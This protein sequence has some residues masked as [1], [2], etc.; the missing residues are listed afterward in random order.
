MEQIGTRHWDELTHEYMHKYKSLSDSM[1]GEHFKCNHFGSQFWKFYCHLGGFQQKGQ[2]PNSLAFSWNWHSGGSGS[3]APHPSMCEGGDTWRIPEL[4]GWWS[5]TAAALAHTARC[6]CNTHRIN[7]H[8]KL[9]HAPGICSFILRLLSCVLQLYI[10]LRLIRPMTSLFITTNVWQRLSL[11]QTSL[12]GWPLIKLWEQNNYFL[13]I[14]T[15]INHFLQNKPS[16]VTFNTKWILFVIFVMTESTC[17]N[18][19]F[20]QPLEFVNIPL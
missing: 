9:S 1:N 13:T 17:I 12:K 15:Q 6:A 20:I 10:C 2:E 11:E 3:S 19:P 4:P 5:D 18:E 7:R 8:N 14:I 16:N